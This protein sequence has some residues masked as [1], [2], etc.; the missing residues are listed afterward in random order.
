VYDERP[1]VGLLA[2]AAK[3][4]HWLPFIEFCIDRRGN[5]SRRGYCDLS[6]WRP[7]QYAEIWVEAA[8][9][10][11]TWDSRYE[12]LRDKVSYPFRHVREGI[13]SAT[14]RAI[15]LAVVFVSFYG[16]P[17]DDFEQSKFDIQVRAVK[18]NL[19]KVTR[20]VRADFYALHL[21]APEI[22]AKSAHKDCPGIAVVGKLY[23]S[24]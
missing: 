8:K 5:N 2:I 13:K 23:K 4:I 19:Y 12:K 21:C 10:A 1:Q 22:V 15:G 20:G 11:L 24:P 7:R 6:I 17:I 3:E 9:I 16:S 14:G 18:R